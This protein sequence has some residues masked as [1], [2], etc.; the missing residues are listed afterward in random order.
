MSQIKFILDA[1]DRAS[2]ILRKEV[3][4][5]MRLTSRSRTLVLFLTAG[6]GGDAWESAFRMHASLSCPSGSL[7]GCGPFS[8][9]RL[10]ALFRPYLVFTC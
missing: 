7:V 5:V 2:N 3:T 6:V 10:C 9:P 1:A 4:C 8:Q